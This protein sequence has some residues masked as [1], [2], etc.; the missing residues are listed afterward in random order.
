MTA[1][2]DK[3]RESQH[4]L[5]LATPGAGKT[6]MAAELAAR[7][8]DAGKI[9]FVLCFSPSITV[10]DGL[11]QTFS[12]RLKRR[13]DGLLGAAGCS[14]TYQSMA[15]LPENFW[16]LLVDNKVL[17]VVDEI[18]HCSGS[19]LENANSWGEEILTKIQSQAAYTLT[20]TGTPW[21]SDKAPIVLSHYSGDEG[22]VQCDYIYGLRDAVRDGV[23]RAPRIVVLDNERIEIAQENEP[24][25]KTFQSFGQM[26]HGSQVK[27]QA[28]ITHEPALLHVLKLGCR[29]L[30]E[31]RRSSPNAGGLVV[32]SSVE[33]A[34]QV[35]RLLQD[36]LKQSAIMV[37]YRQP[38][39]S[40]TI[41]R[42]R[43]TS[44]PW[45]VTV[46]MVS[47]GTDIPR[48]QVCLHVSN[49][50][51]ELHFRQVLGR[52]LRMS[53]A[54][55]QE[56]WLFTFAEPK[57]VEFAGRVHEELPQNSVI[58]PARLPDTVL[59][60]LQGSQSHPE[61]RNDCGDT[62]IG[63]TEQTR[64]LKSPSAA[65]SIDTTATAGVSFKLLGN[66]REQVIAS[67]DSPFHYLG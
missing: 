12:K 30:S 67:F 13:F 59:H 58:L 53:D 45:I 57:L 54:P 18:H 61:P 8:F 37:T 60:I 26:L 11:R 19:T 4:F 3:Y 5:C 46:G 24:T 31:I 28:L 14:Y 10:S 50:K 52:I 39:A 33:H 44:T 6:I 35:M 16:D 62:V 49:V 64:F 40:Q 55:N 29:K 34:V 65:L 9:D 7:L 63:E 15:Y 41:S 1:A 43:R 32:T 36:Q 42:Y 21:R 17:V 38:N 56:A 66:F 25:T 23:C 27:Y 2:L 47:E 20:L 48:L 51:T 22:N